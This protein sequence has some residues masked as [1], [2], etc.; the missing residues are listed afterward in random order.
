MRNSWERNIM[1]RGKGT[2][3]KTRYR[4][5][6]SS[7][8]SPQKAMGGPRLFSNIVWLSTVIQGLTHFASVCTWVPPPYPHR[9]LE[10]QCA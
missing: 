2:I 3:S 9:S 6:T 5:F 10:L 1:Q 4:G 8:T 7:I